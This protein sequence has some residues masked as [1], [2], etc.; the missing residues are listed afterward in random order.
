MRQAFQALLA[1]FGVIVIGISLAHLAIGRNRVAEPA[2]VFYRLRFALWRNQVRSSLMFRWV[3]GVLVLCFAGMVSSVATPG[4]GRGC[5][6]YIPDRA[7]AAV[8]GERALIAG[9]RHHQDILMSL[10]VSGRFGQGGLGVTRA[11]GGRN[12]TR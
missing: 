3:L 4:M 11:L 7:G 8:T 1:L 9:G 5:G 10:R 12:L 2:E 6:A